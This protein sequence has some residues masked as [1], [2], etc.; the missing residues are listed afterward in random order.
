[1]LFDPA[2]SGLESLVFEDAS[3]LGLYFCRVAPV[4]EKLVAREPC[5]HFAVHA[6]GACEDPAAGV[7]GQHGI[8]NPGLFTGFAE[9]FRFLVSDGGLLDL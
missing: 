4:S 5:L 2:E 9:V 7:E 3:D 8:A 6:A 1:V